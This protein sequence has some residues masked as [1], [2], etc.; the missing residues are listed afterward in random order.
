MAL[1]DE[2]RLVLFNRSAVADLGP[3]ETLIRGDTTDAPALEGAARGVDVIVDMAGV[4][5][6]Q[7]FRGKLLP[8]NVLGTYNTF[9]AAR[10]AGVPRLIYA[11][12]HHV[13]GHYPAG[14]R[15]DET[16]PVRPDSMYAV[17]KCFAEAM[18]RLY[19]D[20]AG[21]SVICLRIGFFQDRPIEERHL[22][23][24]I[25]PGDMAR[26]VRCAIQAPSVQFEIVYGVSNNTRRWWDLTRPREVLGYQPEDDSEIYA[27]DLLKEP[28]SDWLGRIRWQGGAKCDLPFMP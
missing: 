26:L 27:K 13:V 1:R 23:V 8:V 24:W 11:S 16:V 14:Q 4:S 10:L 15:L 6:V 2:Y 5:D 12:T 20:K 17:T 19:A 28:P 3:N 21:L 22:A 7:S 18:G 9:E 25:S